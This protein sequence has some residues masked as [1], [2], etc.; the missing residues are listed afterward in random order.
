MANDGN[1][2]AFAGE[3][4]S[5]SYYRDGACWRKAV[6]GG[7]VTPPATSG[8]VS[9]PEVWLSNGT[10]G[11]VIASSVKRIYVG[12]DDPTLAS[13]GGRDVVGDIHIDT[14]PT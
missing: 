13:P 1:C 6:S 11:Y 10:G 2:Y 7:Q 14:V 12:P 9:A 8:A 3:G 5:G 4:G